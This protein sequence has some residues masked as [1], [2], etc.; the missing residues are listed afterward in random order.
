MSHSG[1]LFDFEFDAAHTLKKMGYI[2]VLIGLLVS[3]Y[4]AFQEVEKTSAQLI[5]NTRLI[6]DAIESVGVGLIIYDKNNRFVICN[7]F[8][9]DFYPEITD[10]LVANVHRL[11]IVSEY[12]KKAPNYYEKA[13]HTHDKEN[14]SLEIRPKLTRKLPDGRWLQITEK[15]T[16][17]GGIVAVRTDITQ[18]KEQEDT[19]R[20]HLEDADRSRTAL[21]K[22]AEELVV[23][24]EKLE[25]LRVIAESASTAKSNFLSTMSHEIRTPLNG[26]LGLT[27]LLKD[28]DLS[29]DQENKVNTILS[30]G[31][32]LLAI[33]ND[34]LD[35]SKIEAGGLELEKKAFSLHGLVS[36]ITTPFQSL[37]DDKGLELAFRYEIAP[38]MVV[39]GDP[40]RLR[41]IL[42]NLMSNAI[43]FSEQGRI[44]LTIGA[45]GEETSGDQTMPA[46]K[47]HLLYF[48]VEDT[49]P[50][51]ALDRID[52]I[53]DAFTQED[54][55]I[56]RK[57]GGTGLGLSIVKQ[58]TDLMGGKIKVDSELGK[59]TKFIATIP[60]DAATE[61]EIE[62]VSLRAAVMADRKTEPLNVLIAE[63]NEVNAVIV[64]AFLQKF[65]HSVKHVENGR[66][67]VEVAKEGW[68]DLILMDIHMPEMNGIEATQAIRATE[69]GKTL[70]IVGL[71]AEAF[72]E[73]HAQFIDAGMV[74]VL[75]KPFTEQQLADTLAENRLI[76][77]RNK[78]RD[79]PVT[80]DHASAD[81]AIGEVLVKSDNISLSGGDITPIGHEQKLADFRNQLPA[82]V[83]SS[84]LVEAQ[85][86]L[87]KRLV[88]LR[89]AV[90]DEDLQ[91]VRDTAHAIKGACGSMFAMR[92]AELAAEIEE[93]STDIDAVRDLMD[94]FELATTE[95]TN[96][97][98]EQSA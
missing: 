38:N 20:M 51:I 58:L 35:M 90:Q 79:E 18:L 72:T 56:T 9:R 61:E 83:I 86:S 66:L 81:G 43:K 80:K 37:A 48:A 8:H 33:I 13:E 46:P 29:E 4:A 45:V 59:G 70:P 92:V 60:F 22:Q 14:P 65:G 15:P 36:T 3:M 30:S 63:D 12:I 85:S 49:G 94:R 44:L 96:W 67:A 2:C 76:D 11:D 77:R 89:Q 7:S 6:E 57:Y 93:K 98:A 17:D 24:A 54:N 73:R 21:E 84:L 95:A 41:Q 27:Q 1:A 42:W 78:A 26:V 91:K 82:E 62:V 25:S 69:T 64:K 16:R 68:A 28:T 19:L 10:R 52:A 50:G 88:E 71:T 5:E 32:T 23:L 39:K 34:V 55:T 53:F 40:V 75:T 31:Q 97:W 74:A 47:Y 87:Q